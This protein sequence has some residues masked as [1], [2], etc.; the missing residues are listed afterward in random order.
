[1]NE[2][3]PGGRSGVNTF[4]PEKLLAVF[5][6]VAS[7]KNVPISEETVV[8]VTTILSK[9]LDS[10]ISYDPATVAV[11]AEAVRIAVLAGHG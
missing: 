5:L 8:A 9:D 7:D 11:D 2:G 4:D 6:G 3:P 1:M 10:M